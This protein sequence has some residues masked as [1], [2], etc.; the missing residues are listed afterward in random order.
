MSTTMITRYESQIILENVIEGARIHIS[1]F[2]TDS[3][4]SKD[5]GMEMW[6][7]NWGAFGNSSVYFTTH[8]ISL[9]KEATKLAGKLNHELNLLEEGK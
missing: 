8:F 3:Y 7:I 1:L 4:F 2:K 6:E 9:L 5:K